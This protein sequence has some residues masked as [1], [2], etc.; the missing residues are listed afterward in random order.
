MERGE[1][2]KVMKI[3]VEKSLWSDGIITEML[4]YGGVVVKWIL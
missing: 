3:K 2:G 4:R 1:I